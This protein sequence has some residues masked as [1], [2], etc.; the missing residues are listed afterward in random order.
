LKRIL[1]VNPIGTDAWD[2]SDQDYLSDQASKDTVVEVTSLKEAPTSIETYYQ[3]ASSAPKVLEVIRENKHNYD[4]FI[5]NCFADPAIM[6][7][8]E[9]VDVPVVGPGEASMIIATMLGHKFGI[10]GVSRKSEPM[11][12]EKALALGLEQRLAGV[13]GI[14]IGVNQLLADHDAT[15]GEILRAANN[16]VEEKDAEVIVL[17]C[18]GMLS[19]VEG[20]RYKLQVPVVEPAVTALKVAEALIELGLTHSKIALYSKPETC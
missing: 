7:A 15:Q 14:K 13:I 16:L 18:T 6:A 12:T 10:V 19:F 2:S 11:F 4:A 17:G 1:V 5:V 8:R 9:I 3:Q 20:L